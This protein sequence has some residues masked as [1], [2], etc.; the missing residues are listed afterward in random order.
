M[1]EKF[2]NMKSLSMACSN[3]DKLS[4]FTK[5]FITRI[6][7]NWENVDEIYVSVD[8]ENWKCGGRLCAPVFNTMDELVEFIGSYEQ[9][10]YMDQFF[11]EADEWGSYVWPI[12]ISR[13]PISNIDVWRDDMEVTYIKRGDCFGL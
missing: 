13:L 4:D 6:F 9:L 2:K 8:L 5:V 11:E 3:W 12:I 10:Y 7:N 1:S